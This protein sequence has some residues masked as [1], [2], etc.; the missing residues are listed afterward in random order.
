MTVAI[1]GG[2]DIPCVVRP[3]LVTLRQRLWLRPLGRVDEDVVRLCSTALQLLRASLII[4]VVDEPVFGV[5]DKAWCGY[6]D[7]LYVRSFSPPRPAVVL[8][9]QLEL[10][11]AHL[12]ARDCEIRAPP[13]YTALCSVGQS[14]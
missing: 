10:R 9:S 2:V 5:V 3:H 4:V 13:R 11:V 1:N 12:G 8:G 6:E 14:A 7:V